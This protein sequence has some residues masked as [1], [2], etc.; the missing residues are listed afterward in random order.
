M[1]A[2]Y[3]SIIL[4]YNLS[5]TQAMTTYENGIFNGGDSALTGSGSFYLLPGGTFISGHTSGING[6]IQCSG[7]KFFSDSARY[8]FNGTSAQVVGI[9][10]PDTVKSIIIENASSGVAQMGRMIVRDTMLFI[11]GNFYTGPDTVFLMPEARIEG[12]KPNSYIVGH[13][14]YSKYVGTGSSDFGGMGVG[15]S[16]GSDDLGNMM[17]HRISGVQGLV[18]L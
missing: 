7:T 3:G 8:H 10:L 11:S 14:N 17:V 4:N 5:I 1:V 6:N 16:S 18:V 2:N 12:E 13:L 9:Y 15:I